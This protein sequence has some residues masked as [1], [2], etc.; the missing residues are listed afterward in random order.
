VSI[1][2]VIPGGI[3]L[4]FPSYSYEE[5]VYQQFSKSGI[6]LKIEREKKVSSYFIDS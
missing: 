6:I 4:F 1:S 5:Q 2:E 3:V